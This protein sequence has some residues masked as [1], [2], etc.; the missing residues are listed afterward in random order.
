MVVQTSMTNELLGY[1]T[2]FHCS[3]VSFFREKFF[4]F[5]GSLYYVHEKRRER[6]GRVEV[7][8]LDGF[9]K[10]P[11]MKV[12]RAYLHCKTIILT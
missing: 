6:D 7:A 11:Q 12:R 9:L 4:P 8:R 3:P 1:F 5:D 2:S 10:L